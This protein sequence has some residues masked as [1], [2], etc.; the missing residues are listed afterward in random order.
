MVLEVHALFDEAGIPD[1]GESGE[2][3]GLLGRA[4]WVLDQLAALRKELA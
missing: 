3:L 4:R 2:H 1:E